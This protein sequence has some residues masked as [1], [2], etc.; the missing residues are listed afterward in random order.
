MD[1]NDV[2]FGNSAPAMGFDVGTK[3][4]GRIISQTAIQRKEVV[5]NKVTGQIEQGKHLYW[6][7][8][9]TT[10]EKTD[11]PVM[12]PVL[13]V[14][15]TFRNWE[16]VSPQRPKIGKDD[17]IR[18]IFIK[19]RSKQNPGSLMDAVI[20]AVRE[21]G[22]RKISV[23]DYIELS[24]T[25]EGKKANRGMNAPKL[26][27]GTY[28]SADNPPAWASEVEP[29]DSGDAEPGEDDNPFDLS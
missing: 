13:T 4:R 2:L 12:D 19:G 24:C 11:R 16:G 21:A 29:E 10:T 27:E 25:G 23:G 7:D 8:G 3:V 1:A 14:Q 22:V 28:W 26:Y 6:K 20:L 15:T 5:P 18:Q 17:G 9:K